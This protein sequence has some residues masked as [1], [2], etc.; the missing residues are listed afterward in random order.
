MERNF[1]QYRIPF[2]EFPLKKG[3]RKKATNFKQ[4]LFFFSSVF[5]ISSLPSPWCPFLSHP[6]YSPQI[7]NACFCAMCCGYKGQQHLCV[8]F[9]LRIY[10]LVVSKLGCMMFTIYLT[11]WVFKPCEA[12]MACCRAAAGMSLCSGCVCLCAVLNSLH[13]QH[14]TRPCSPRSQ[15][16]VLAECWVQTSAQTW[17]SQTRGWKSR[18]ESYCFISRG[19]CDGTRG[20]WTLNRYIRCH[21]A[22]AGTERGVGGASVQQKVL[23]RISCL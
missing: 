14:L 10:L 19:C 18:S 20:L 8:F 12:M 21:A 5:L 23:F 16:H 17:R 11:Y 13:T 2:S 3:K 9:L 15:W 22:A 4:K 6:S 7:L 1:R